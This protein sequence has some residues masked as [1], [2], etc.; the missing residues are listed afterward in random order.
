MELRLNTRTAGE[1]TVVAV[2][3]EV[4]NSTAP[5]LWDA[6]VQAFDGGAAIGIVDLSET[7]FLDS[8]GLG[9]LVGIGKR[10]AGTGSVLHVVCPRPQLRKLFEISHLDE[11]IPLFD[12]VDDAARSARSA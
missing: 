1:S 4:D 8:S 5:Q 3:G 7:E 6:L 9:V 2:G 10:Q 12:S 11:V